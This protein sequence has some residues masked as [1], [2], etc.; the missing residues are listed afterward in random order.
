MKRRLKEIHNLLLGNSFKKKE[1]STIRVIEP[2]KM[3]TEEEGGTTNWELH[4][5]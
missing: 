1:G 2:L 4:K 3:G 5:Q